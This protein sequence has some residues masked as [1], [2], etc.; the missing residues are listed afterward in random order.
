MSLFYVLDIDCNM[1][2]QSF[3][4]WVDLHC[5]FLILSLWSFAGGKSRDILWEMRKEDRYDAD[6]ELS[7]CERVELEMLPATLHGS[8]SSDVQAKSW[9]AALSQ[10][11]ANLE[12]RGRRQARF[13]IGQRHPERRE[14]KFQKIPTCGVGIPAGFVGNLPSPFYHASSSLPTLSEV[15]SSWL[16]ITSS[17]YQAWRIVGPDTVELSLNYYIVRKLVIDTLFLVRFISII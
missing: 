6:I 2:F 17:F 15:L 13:Q 10:S 7:K 5:Q 8:I 9:E 3:Y 1:I 16:V 4:S 14:A 11:P 12:V